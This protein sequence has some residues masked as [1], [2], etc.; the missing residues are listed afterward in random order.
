MDGVVYPPRQ[1]SEASA[2]P[3]DAC[4]APWQRASHARGAWASEEKSLWEVASKLTGRYSYA[5]ADGSTHVGAC[6]LPRPV[7]PVRI[8]RVA[9]EQP[10]GRQQRH[11]QHLRVTQR[12]SSQSYQPGHLTQGGVCTSGRPISLGLCAAV[13]D[14]CVHGPWL[15]GARARYTQ[16]LLAGSDDEGKDR[17]PEGDLS[18]CYCCGF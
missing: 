13:G 11:H 17:R 9:A 1:L 6:L 3:Q 8:P 16:A 2:G 12:L 18:E 10:P 4:L 15:R 14:F 5:H 7:D